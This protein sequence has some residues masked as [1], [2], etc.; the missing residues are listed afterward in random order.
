M[1][2]FLWS[3]KSSSSNKSDKELNNSKKYSTKTQINSSA[4][5]TSIASFSQYIPGRSSISTNAVNPNSNNNNNTMIYANGNSKPSRA[6]SSSH[7]TQSIHKKSSSMTVNE[8]APTSSRKNSNISRESYLKNNIS[9]PIVSMFRDNSVSSNDN[10]GNNNIVTHNLNHSMNDLGGR[11][12]YSATSNDNSL[13]NEDVRSIFSDEI[14]DNYSNKNN[15]IILK[16]RESSNISNILQDTNSEPGKTF[17]LDSSTDYDSTIFRTGWLNKS[18]GQI[19]I[20]T[21]TNS[22]GNINNDSDRSNLIL[23]PRERSSKR[24]SRIFSG[25]SEFLDSDENL[26]KINNNDSSETLD[27]NQQILVPDYKTYRAQ[28]KGSLFLLYK[29]NLTND[30]K[31]FDPNLSNTSID[32]SNQSPS[33]LSPNNKRATIA[34]SLNTVKNS[35]SHPYKNNFN[36]PT[37]KHNSSENSVKLKYLSVDFPHPDLSQDSE[38]GKVLNGTVESLCH[39][40]LFF[41][42]DDTVGSRHSSV[43]ISNLLLMLPLIDSFMKFLCVFNQFGLTFTRHSSKLTSYASQF[44]HITKETDTLLTERLALIVTTILDVFPGFL[45]NDNIFQG[46]VTLLDTISLHNDEISNDLKILVAQK[47]NR[48]NKLTFFI[49]P[50]SADKNGELLSYNKNIMD[51]YTNVD[52]FLNLDIKEFANEVHDINMRFD[53]IW[54]PRFDYSLLYYSKNV[55]S[56]ITALNPLV[57]NNSDNVHFLGRLMI[58]HL[59]PN[60]PAHNNTNAQS[61]HKSRAKI[62]VKWVQ[63]GCRLEHLGDMVLWLTIATIIC[64]I[65]IL[66]LHRSWQYVPESILKII[67]KDWVPTVIQLDRRQMSSKSTSS[68]FIL[69]PPNLNDPFIRK[70]VISYFGDLIV[71]T[72]DLPEQST[73]KYIE[74]KMTRTKNAF[75]KWQQRLAAI[76]FQDNEHSSHDENDLDDTFDPR[77]N[78]LYHFWKY[79]ISQPK[80][81]IE[82]IMKLSLAFEPPLIDQNSFSHIGSHRSALLTGSYLPILFNDL[83]SNYSLFTR[84]CLVGAAGSLVSNNHTKMAPPRSSARLSKAI[85]ISDPI[86]QMALPVLD[87]ESNPMTGIE[88]IDG[89]I[90]RELKLISNNKQLLMKSIRDV[91]NINMEFFNISD[92][93]IFKSVIDN[94]RSRPASVVLESPTKMAEKTKN[95]SDNHDSLDISGRLSR[96]IESMDFFSDINNG[97]DPLQETIIDV[98]VKSASLE[99]L[100][101]LIVLTV[102]IFSKLIN[103]KDLGNFYNKMS[104]RRSATPSEDTV[105]LLDFA[106]VKLSMN[107][108]LFTETF[109]NTYKSFSTTIAVLQNLAKRFIGA[110]SCAYSIEQMLNPEL[111]V[112]TM[113][114]TVPFAVWDSKISNDV[115]VNRNFILKIQIGTTEAILHLVSNHFEDF[116]DN[117]R[118]HTMM[119]DLLKIMEQEISTEWPAR[120]EA[121]KNECPNEDVKETEMLLLILGEVFENIKSNYQRQ[122]YRPV[123]ITKMKKRIVEHVESYENISF[124]DFMTRLH[125]EKSD[126]GLLTEFKTLRFYQYANLLEWISKLDKLI[127]GCFKLVSKKEW[128]VLYELVELSSKKALTS[129]FQYTLHDSSKNIINSG[130]FQLK[131]LQISNIFT[132]LTTLQTDSYGEKLFDKIPHSIQLLLKLHDSLTKFFTSQIIDTERS[133]NER[134]DTYAVI[135]QMLNYVRWKTSSLDLFDRDTEGDISPHVPSFIETAL[136][137]SIVCPESRCNELAWFTASDKLIESGN[138]SQIKSVD[139]IIANIDPIHIRGFLEIDNVYMT[140]TRALCPCPGWF[141]SRLLDI[142][143]FVPAMDTSNTKLINFDKRRFVNNIISN[144]IEMVPPTQKSNADT[145]NSKWGDILFVNIENVTFSYSQHVK[146]IASEDGKTR[147]FQ[148]TG[149]FNQLLSNEVDKIR[150]EEKK[151]DLLKIQELENKRSKQVYTSSRNDRGLQSTMRAS[152]SGLASI[153]SHNLSDFGS[154]NRNKRNSVAPLPSR[155]ATINNTNPSA[156]GSVSKKIGGFFRRPFSIANFNTSTPQ[157]SSNSSQQDHLNRKSI[158]PELLP[159]IKND[160]ISDSKPVL[161]IKTFEIKNVM[162]IINHRNNTGYIYTFK[163][164]MQDGS[165]HM[166]QAKNS[167]DLHEWI[168]MIKTSKRY[169]FRSKKFKGKTHNKVFGVPL[170]SICERES[171]LIPTIV[172]KLLEEIE[173]RGLD[174]VGLY[175]I[176]GSVGSINLLKKAFDEEGAVSNNFSLDDD[177]WFEINAI[178]GCF[179]MYLRELPESLFT[180]ELITDFTRSVQK[181]KSH[182]IEYDEFKGEMIDKLTQLPR[183]NYETLKR[184]VLHLNKVHRHVDNNRMDASNLAIVFSMSFI[185]QENLANSMGPVLGAVQTILQL[186]IKDPMDF[187]HSE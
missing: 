89:P 41:K 153:S 1:K 165:E 94:E 113:N 17:I 125:D 37:N 8:S 169:S 143:Q 79:H 5:S 72:D 114:D 99:R 21:H 138:K 78:G 121:T 71:M 68:V 77:N 146:A 103:T 90:M 155:G 159:E 84:G 115:E 183:C 23:S 60:N 81:N 107:N 157:H 87:F 128:I 63:I 65:P 88:D 161:T 141:I 15:N 184:I 76:N 142:S 3:R 69:A 148:E 95:G 147:K 26:N 124:D 7:A 40:I 50:N 144:V 129:F 36:G 133:F 140:S 54:A 132:W 172:I 57:F 162:E 47:H 149:L 75:Y 182:E 73:L 131:D 11:S 163:V 120:I 82:A 111:K 85:V 18:H 171:T 173:L 48:L 176:P 42:N 74:K 109:F 158:Q 106:F 51:K 70:N 92:D 2:G 136:C 66:R 105:G 55:D 112:E 118:C 154:S 20:S 86:Q 35:S 58:S 62:L 151:Y 175:R 110:K 6:V 127:S 168:R 119:L 30:F 49:R 64:S 102:S 31:S 100:L 12:T 185:D 24:D 152:H 174:E 170:E 14:N 150:R 180:N 43:N 177:R 28:L 45:L 10:N 187:F 34:G 97:S 80:L 134:V 91:F 122:L 164:I 181:F 167:V 156:S 22:N 13:K 116:T 27:N 179:K 93:L 123:G 186:F 101:D 145:L 166:I 67:F 32:S 139:D 108:D 52:S 33:Q 56:N 130:S 160:E 39:T 44:C 46:T 53:K 98:V 4:S 38:S 126:S 83:L 117:F 61:Y 135:L 16:K 104:K 178:A 19:V 25:S 96:T 59:F 137:N 29:N 9:Q